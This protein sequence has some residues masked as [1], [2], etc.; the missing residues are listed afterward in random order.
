MTTWV[1]TDAFASR[2]DSLMRDFHVPGLSVAVWHNGT[3]YARS[4]GR[5]TIDDNK[6]VDR[7]TIFDA[8]STS[9][10]LTSLCMGIMV[11]SHPKLSKS[12]WKTPV[13]DLIKSDF[14]MNRADDTNVITIE[15]LLSH[16]SGFSG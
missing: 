16:T 15:D 4:F 9:K 5:A 8:A 11:D 12:G 1:T 10:I 7:D 14:I 3:V 13:A 6:P 2:V